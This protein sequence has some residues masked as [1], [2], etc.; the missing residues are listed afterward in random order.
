MRSGGTVRLRGSCASYFASTLCWRRKSPGALLKWRMRIGDMRAAASADSGL[1]ETCLDATA[2]SLPAEQGQLWAGAKQQN[3]EWGPCR[4]S[5]HA[6][7]NVPSLTWQ[8]GES[9]QAKHTREALRQARCRLG[10]LSF[11]KFIEAG[12]GERAW[13]NAGAQW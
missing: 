4:Q 3:A 5:M 2:A 8:Q 7:R 12:E 10:V 13:A 1:S 9:A 11:T 6:F